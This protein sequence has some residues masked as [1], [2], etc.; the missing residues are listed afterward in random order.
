MSAEALNLDDSTLSPQEVPLNPGLS[1][2]EKQQ[3]IID[4]W[5]L[6]I[7]IANT[8]KIPSGHTLTY[9]DL[10]Q[11]G[12]VGLVQA[13]ERF[14]PQRGLS[15]STFATYRIAGSIKDAIRDIDTVSRGD[16]RKISAWNDAELIL[17][18][19]L[20]RMPTREELSGYLDLDEQEVREIEMAQTDA[21][22]PMSLDGP[23]MSN[24]GEEALTFIETLADTTSE[25]TDSVE[26]RLT[27]TGILS[28]IINERT[29]YIL[30]GY[31][32]V[33]LT[34]KEIGE[35]LGIH[36]SRVSQIMSKQLDLTLRRMQLREQKA[37]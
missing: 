23:N 33:G 35:D 2:A 29:R 16:V 3:L 25:S 4:R 1:E 30:F 24:Y 32:Y 26:D 31:Y 20:G 8:I 27:A 18:Q 28:S 9:E 12:F 19:E 7:A 15:F 10:V 5:G 36:E 22:L 13:V 17:T 6:V 37:A 14:D 34:K 21:S 11:E